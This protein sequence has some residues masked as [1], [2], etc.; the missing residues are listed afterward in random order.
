ML[1]PETSFDVVLEPRDYLPNLV[2]QASISIFASAKVKPV[3]DGE[4]KFVC[5]DH[6]VRFRRPDL[7]VKVKCLKYKYSCIITQCI[8]S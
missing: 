1:S 2:E 4:H 8:F 6:D 3:G 5:I 7:E